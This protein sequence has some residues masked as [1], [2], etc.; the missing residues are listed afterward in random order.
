[1]SLP[2]IARP[3]VVELDP[4]DA[5]FERWAEGRAERDGFLW[6]SEHGMGRLRVTDPPYDSDY[7]A[8]Y[9]RLAATP[10]GEALTAARVTLVN[11]YTDRHVVDIGI[12]CGAFIAARMGWTW[13]YD[14]NPAGIA[15]LKGNTPGFG[16]FRDPYVELPESISLWDVLEHIPDPGALLRRVSEY[17]FASLPI[18]P[19]DGPP[20]PVWKHYKPREHCWYWTEPGIIRWMAEHG[21]ALRERSRIET[22]LGRQDIGTYVFQRVRP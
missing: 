18:V 21:F 6:L 4:R 14:V 12:G 1:M 22:N 8:N 19:G 3:D 17:V 10:M 7:F 13:G 9:Q 5:V 15:W 16:R 20:T 11:R 2:A